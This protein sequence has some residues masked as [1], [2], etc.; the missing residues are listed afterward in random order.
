MEKKRPD[1]EVYIRY[2]I[3]LILGVFI[4]IFY[5]IFFPLTIYPVYFILN[6]FYSVSIAGKML[7]FAEGGIEIINACVAGSAYYL[8]LILN[9]TTKIKLKKRI[10]S[11]LFSISSLLILNILRILF[12]SILYLNNSVFFDITHKIFWYTLSILFVVAIW[13]LTVHIFKIKNIPIY[14]DFK[15]LKKQLK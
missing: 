12:L 5:K 7:V 11:I 4:S 3:L 6:L 10:Y 8:L 9:L 1:L 13:F 14:S 2:I 15:N